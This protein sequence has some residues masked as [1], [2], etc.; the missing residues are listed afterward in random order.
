MVREKKILVM[1]VAIALVG[2]AISLSGCVEEKKDE[3]KIIVGTSADFPPFEFIDE[4][5]KITGFD[6]E[7]ILTSLG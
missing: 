1:I 7:V 6:I 4:G 3:N 2:L 5:G